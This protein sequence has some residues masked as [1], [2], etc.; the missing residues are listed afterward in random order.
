MKKTPS[1]CISIRRLNQLKFAERTHSIPGVARR[2]GVGIV[3]DQGLRGGMRTLS[4]L[5]PV[6]GGARREYTD[7]N[8]LLLDK[9]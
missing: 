2:K 7:A 8:M 9:V 6:S 4:Y 5:T 1:I 3:G